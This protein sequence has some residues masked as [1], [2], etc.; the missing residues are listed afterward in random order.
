G[1]LYLPLGNQTPDQLGRGR[2]A[3]AEKFSSSITALAL[4]T[5]QLRWVR[6][7]GPQDLGDMDVPAQPRLVDIPTAKGGVPARV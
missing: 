7:T 6:Q 3:N 1:L 4:N 2:S 5:G